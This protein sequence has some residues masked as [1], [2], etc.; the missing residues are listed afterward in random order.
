MRRFLQV[1]Q[2]KWELRCLRREFFFLRP[3]SSRWDTSTDGATGGGPE[4]ADLRLVGFLRS[5]GKGFLR[6]ELKT[7]MA[8]S[9]EGNGR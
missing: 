6:A 5:G 4:L 7:S 2:P 3:S 9:W 8:E 1:P